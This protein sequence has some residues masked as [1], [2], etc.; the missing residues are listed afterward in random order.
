MCKEPGSFGT[1]G[2][3]VREGLCRGCG[4]LSPGEVAGPSRGIGIQGSSSPGWSRR[5][6]L[7]R[8]LDGGSSSGRDGGRPGWFWGSLRPPP[9]SLSRCLRATG[10]VTEAATAAA[11]A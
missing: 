2:A 9:A 3:W 4:L 10:L 6:S 7:L 11:V 8:G 5:P 1:L